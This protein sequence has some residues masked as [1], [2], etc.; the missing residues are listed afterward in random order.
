MTVSLSPLGGAASQFFDNNGVILSGGKIYTY[1]AGTTT[2]RATYTSSSGATP[3]ANPIILDSAGRVPGGEIWLTDGLVYKFVIETST[4]SLLG[5][6]DNINAIDA[7]SSSAL[8]ASGGAALVGSNDGASGTL[9]TTVAGFITYLR[10]SVGSSIVGFL[11]AG[12]GAVA[13][14]SQAKMR[15]VVN[16]TDFGA[17]NNRAQIIAAL[18][19]ADT[20][21]GKGATVVF[22]Q[23][24]WS[25]D[26]NIDLSA[27]P[28]VKLKGAGSLSTIINATHNGVMFT[29]DGQSDIELSGM[30]LGMS[31]GSSQVGIDLKATASSAFRFKANDMQIA[32]NGAAGQIG[33]RAIVTGAN[34]IT[35]CY[36]NDIDIIQ[37]DK[38]FVEV[39]TEGN[40]W[41]GIKVNQYGYSGAVVTASIATNVLTVTAV[42]SGTLAQGQ[43][44]TGTNVSKGTFIT[45]LLTGTGGVG[46][47]E[48]S[49]FQTTAAT[50]ITAA[51]A[52]IASQ[53][54]ANVY[55][56]RAAGTVAANTVG[57]CQAGTR[58]TVESLV[59]DIG[60]GGKAIAVADNGYNTINVKRPE[61]LTPLGDV[62]INNTILDEAEL[63]ISRIGKFRGSPPSAANFTLSAEWGSTATVTAV[64]GT[65]QGVQFT[66]NSSGVG[67]AANPTCSYSY[68]NGTW[69]NQP[70]G[71]IVT[72]NGGNQ[73]ST[74]TTFSQ[75]ISTVNWSFRWAA[76]PV[77][78]ESYV[79]QVILAG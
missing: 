16:V 76:T 29:V 48:V 12:T 7:V 66:I 75:G 35:D 74:D 1:A 24:V 14:T 53:G 23:G 67:Q 55:E 5:T 78:G 26:A 37:V 71:M 27:Y 54:L 25:I 36:A 68:A 15:D 3:H 69:I 49:N 51:S 41:K 79:F 43:V 64:T 20:A 59:V 39:G 40:F 38:P 4:G 56:G 10:S 17:T 11:Q 52:A 47:Y 34:I 21:G 50:T 45:K 72:R 77:A 65:D 62:G 22:P 57:F 31:V 70:L 28:R 46:T 13:R 6:Y 63:Y 32:G 60:S 73:T 33:I 30:R 44:I 8:A 19:A 9:W 42:A 2:P 61:A 18:A 58:N